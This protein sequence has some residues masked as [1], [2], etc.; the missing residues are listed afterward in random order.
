MRLL[1]QPPITRA[2]RGGGVCSL[3]GV[4]AMLQCFESSV[5][6]SVNVFVGP[7]WCGP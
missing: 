5:M 1:F 3:P 7:D 2:C 6:I 4:L